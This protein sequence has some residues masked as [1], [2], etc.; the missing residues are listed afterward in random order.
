MEF[1]VIE[2]KQG[3]LSANDR[4]ADGLRRELQE[5][6]TFLLNLMSS[7]GSGKTS[8]LMQTIPRLTDSLRVGVMEADI[9][10]DVDART[11]LR[12]RRPGDSAPHRRHVPPGCGDDPSGPQ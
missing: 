6:K 12:H 3:V 5:K 1:K 9:D 10:S 4:E 8:T 7:P 11:R 2:I